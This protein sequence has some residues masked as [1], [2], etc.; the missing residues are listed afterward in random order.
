MLRFDQIISTEM[1]FDAFCSHSDFQKRFRLFLRSFLNSGLLRRIA[2]KKIIPAKKNLGLLPGFLGLR[3]GLG[4][5][6]ELENDRLQ[7]GGFVI[8]CCRRRF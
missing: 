8:Y 7:Q 6:V 2:G 3:S 4:R 5:L 1:S